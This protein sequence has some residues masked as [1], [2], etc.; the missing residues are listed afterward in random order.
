MKISEVLPKGC[1]SE[2]YFRYNS[3]LE[4]YTNLGSDIPKLSEIFAPPFG[5]APK[6]LLCSL[7]LTKEGQ[8]KNNETPFRITNI[9]RNFLREKT[10]LAK[11]FR[12][13]KNS[14]SL[15]SSP[16]LRSGRITGRYAVSLRYT[17]IGYLRL[18]IPAKPLCEIENEPLIAS[19]SQNIY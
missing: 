19:L 2:V 9:K 11:N 14:S 6:I 10:T 7:R 1:I 13:R 3:Q 16:S 18:R 4:V 5:L 15:R 17:Q 8:S 12:R